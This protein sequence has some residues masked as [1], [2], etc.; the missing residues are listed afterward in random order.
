MSGAAART[1]DASGLSVS[2]ARGGVTLPPGEAVEVDSTGV[3]IIAQLA[4]GL[5]I[6]DIDFEVETANDELQVE[7]LDDRCV[8][9]SSAGDGVT[10]AEVSWVSL[11]WRARR[12]VVEV[13]VE[14]V[15]APAAGVV[16]R[17]KL[18]DDGPWYAPVP[19]SLP[20]NARVRL[21]SYGAKRLMVELV[22]RDGERLLP[23]TAA[24]HTV[25]VRV[26]ASPPDLSLSIERELVQRLDRSLSPSERWRVHQ[27]LLDATRRTLAGMPRSDTRTFALTVR[28]S[29]KGVLR[30]VVVS[31]AARVEVCRW[32]A[33]GSSVTLRVSPGSPARARIEAPAGDAELTGLEFGVEARLPSERCLALAR[34]GH[35]FTDACRCRP[36]TI[37]AQRL[38]T[39]AGAARPLA[40]ELQL[41]PMSRTLRAAV[42]LHRDRFGVPEGEPVVRERLEFRMESD[43]EAP[44]AA[45]WVSLAIPPPLSLAMRG[46]PLWA[47]L[48]VEEGDAL[49]SLD[50]AEGS[51]GVLFRRGAE[52]WREQLVYV[53]SR[54]GEAASSRPNGRAAAARVRLR[55]TAAEPPSASLRLR[56]R[57]REIPL[58]ADAAGR[59]AL[60]PEELGRLRAG[61]ESGGADAIELVAQSPVS[62]DISLFDLRARF[63]ATRRR[64]EF[65]RSSA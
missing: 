63:S 64:F 4:R 21:P 35:G 53:A 23:A 50:P 11:D 49:W 58:V 33:G 12:T 55:V 47:L 1:V 43:A 3:Q 10:G 51:P 9:T 32:A 45:S 62:G 65:G 30:R 34:H 60:S 14:L 61:G 6:D 56:W 26:L 19:E 59:V 17:L 39:A 2:L 52:T 44:W 41:M 16:G 25:S 57:A 24:V 20:L 31:A 38:P 13:F 15:N 54:H 22:R 42:A 8:W 48:T 7:R 46:V 28:A 37:T 36:G 27:P 29:S 18:A 40:L 5:V